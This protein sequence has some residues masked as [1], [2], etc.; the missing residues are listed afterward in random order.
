MASLTQRAERVIFMS[1]PRARAA[2]R[3]ARLGTIYSRTT[4]SC[5]SKIIEPAF[6]KR[7]RQKWSLT[8]VLYCLST[9]DN[10][11]LQQETPRKYS[12]S[13]ERLAWRHRP[14]QRQTSSHQKRYSPP[15][16][17]RLGVQQQNFRQT[18]QL[19]NSLRVF[20]SLLVAQLRPP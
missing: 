16:L 14:P 2:T 20:Q 6:R 7:D 10:H 12:R 13:F 18:M 15:P 17:R 11:P 4:V 5:G 8:S 3:F 9:L 19:P 1:N